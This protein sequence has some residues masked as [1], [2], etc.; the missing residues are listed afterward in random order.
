MERLFFSI[1][2]AFGFLGVA[3]GAFAAH[4]LKAR[5]APEQLATFEVGVRYQLDAR[6]RVAG[7]GVGAHPMARPT[8]P[9]QRLVVRHRHAAVL[10]Q[11]LRVEPHRRARARHRHADRW[12]RPAG[13]MVVPAVGTVAPDALKPEPCGP[14]CAAMETSHRTFPAALHDLAAMAAL[15]ERLERQ[16]RAASAEQYRHVVPQRE[17]TARRRR[18]WRCTERAARGGAGHGRNLRE[19]AVRPRGPVPFAAA[20]VPRQPSKPPRR[21][22]SDARRACIG[23]LRVAPRVSA[24][25]FTARALG[26]SREG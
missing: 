6:P 15:L 16:P 5:L 21:P 12:H 24:C 19:P 4:A 11:P 25:G 18:A 8:S 13:R 7:S 2:C 23:L 14:R 17:Q 9:L 20:S 1:G 22:S 10:G 3:L 26:Q